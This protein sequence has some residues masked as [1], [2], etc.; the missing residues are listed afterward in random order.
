MAS[1]FQA[2][3]GTEHLVI[4]LPSFHSE[5]KV[6]V[7]EDKPVAAVA[8][9]A[10]KVPAFVQKYPGRKMENR[11]RVAANF[12]GNSYCLCFVGFTAK[13]LLYKPSN[14][15]LN[16]DSYT[17]HS[18]KSQCPNHESSAVKCFLHHDNS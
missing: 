17:N 9:L 16:Q 6:E 10:D 3:E 4:F 11:I 12:P 15:L 8:R 14:S 13:L 18:Y 5:G 1:P 7:L 2:R